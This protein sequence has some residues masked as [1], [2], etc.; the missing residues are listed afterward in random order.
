MARHQ[1]FRAV[2]G[3][4]I[5]ATTCPPGL[6]LPAWPDLDS[7]DISRI[8][9]WIREA[10]LLPGIADV[11]TVASPDLAAAL[12]AIC[13]DPAAPRPVR[14]VRRVA[15]SLMRYLLRWA[16]RATPFGLFAGVA[17]VALGPAALVRFGDRH[18][19]VIRP[20]GTW[21]TDTV[22]ALEAT[23]ELLRQLSVMASNLGFAR[24]GDWVL[25]CQ[26]G[27]DGG[28]VSEVSVRATAAVRMVLQETVTPVLFS[29]LLA[30][31]A[32]ESPQTPPDVV[33][34]MLAGLV[35][36]RVLLTSLWPPMT[37]TDPIAYLSGQVGE[38]RPAVVSGFDPGARQAVGVRLDC[39]VAL[40]PTVIVEAERAAAILVRLAPPRPAWA[41][42]HAAFTDR[43]GPGALVGVVELVDPDRG[44]GY[45]AGFR[46]SLFRSDPPAIGRD[47]ALAAI[48]QKAALD[49]C[50]EEILDEGLLDSLEA[51]R[52][53]GTVPHT[54]LRFTVS[55]PTPAALDAG[56]F[57]LT[58]VSASRH[59]GT[60]VGRFLHLLAEPDRDSIMR[61]YQELPV[62]TAGAIAVQI[63]S[64]PL[65]ARTDLL[66]R[67]PQVLPVLSL[68]EHRRL[69]GQ[70]ID[71]ADLAVTADASR[72][73]LV[74]RSRGRAVEPLIFSAADL[75]HRAHPLARFLCEVST[76]TAAPCTPLHWGPLAGRLP[77]LPRVRAG[78]I[79][80]SPARWNLT[81]AD[82]PAAS[83]GSNGEW[84][85]QFSQFRRSR[86]IP[87]AVRLGDDD[88]LLR[89]D[90]TDPGHLT[91]LRR[92]LNRAGT[93]ALAEDGGD[94]GWI[95]GRA[96]EIVVPL[97][98]QAPPRPLARTVRPGRAWHGPGHLPGASPWIQAS[99]SGHPGRHTEL[100]TEWL[101]DL[102]GRWAHG[103]VGGWWFIRSRTPA[104][105]LRIRLPLH[106]PGAYGP[107]AR[108]LGEWARAVCDA[109][110]LA[111]VSLGTYR[112]ETGRYGTG[113]AMA[114]AE[115]VFA[116]DSAYAVEYLR[117]AASA[118]AATAAGMI[119]LANAFCGDA[120]PV[121]LAGHL[122]H[123][124]G[125]ALDR[126]VL[127]QV[128]Q[129]SAVPPGLAGRRRS[130]VAAYRALLHDDEA[131][132]VLADLLHLHHARMIGT[133]AGS[134][135]RCLRLARAAAQNLIARGRSRTST[136]CSSGPAPAPTA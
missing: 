107:A 92:H 99:L 81:S 106:D 114:A 119:S 132:I 73:I 23:P 2:D 66:A 9:G 31:L 40:P 52:D 128:L 17:P 49:G 75:R 11:V 22:T 111:D 54:E 90:L 130:A 20:G 87:D 121:W 26:P 15:E 65:T 24:G 10:W 118:E 7:S 103:P 57:T 38:V 37:E 131:D 50:A 6:A 13:A 84:D 82:L 95:G 30:K 76:A 60:S 47:T 91:L 89:L 5:R 127:A 68:G 70:D 56:D 44:L 115:A 27:R 62:S 48:A 18:M 112:P 58:V 93:A 64:P 74:S 72:L 29:D 61:A 51:N 88:V 136:T 8:T 3:A 28:Q 39:D 69:G 77:F 85:R 125:P 42:Y 1:S 34:G 12:A 83:T 117:T 110:L 21:V 80:L 105:H 25:P 135:R 94:F 41:A 16:S 4:I 98:S 100:L 113:P 101:P 96:H 116:A 124:G 67:A 79:I 133:D 55:A 104:P 59:A 35:R 123:G 102:L 63:S 45:P 97:A 134:E 32:A 122:D 19:T 71:L 109:G 86:R 46:G 43:Y 108:T 126:S 33:E 129:P 53:T 120:A 36:L 14:Q 78:R